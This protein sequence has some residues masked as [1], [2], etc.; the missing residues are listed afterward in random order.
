MQPQKL[1]QS[2]LSALRG[3][4]GQGNVLTSDEHRLCYA[5][6][7]QRLECVPDAIVRPADTAQIA[8][9][10]RLANENA[11]PVIPRGAGTGLS[12]GSVAAAGGVVL[13]VCRLDRI[14]QIDETNMLLTAQPGVVTAKLVSAAEKLGLLYPPDPGSINACTIGGNVAENS[15]GLRA[16][17]Y[18]VTGDYLKALEVVSPLGEVYR[19]GA[20]TVKSVAGY[21]VTSL[22]CGSEGTLG[23]LTEITV[24]LIPIPRFRRSLLAVFDTVRGAT[25]AVVAI[26]TCGVLPATLEMM[27]GMTI[28]HVE[29]ANHIGLPVEA[30]AI[31]LIEVDGYSDAGVAEE[32]EIVRAALA[33]SEA[34]EMKT[35]D[36]PADRERLWEA[37]RSAI[38]A[39]ARAR[40]TTML[41]DVTVPVTA[42]S[43]MTLFI[44]Q[45]AREHS[46]SVATFGHAG[47]GNLHPT[48]LADDRDE[49]E[50]AR[51]KQA[52]AEIFEKAIALGGTVSGEH[53]IGMTKTRFLPMETGPATIEVMRS[54]K[55]AMDPNNILNPGKVFFED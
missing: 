8:A 9:V 31:L 10:L 40:P 50:I 43:E 29:Q 13:D 55:R 22:L 32:A 30:E 42:L 16:V 5:Y 15:G 20:R 18:G 36:N 51:V 47:D 39:L 3:I 19:T 11:F 17:K 4:V 45:M 1:S 7:A 53:G 48:F 12:G 6:D 27:D 34:S 49:D 33:K 2:T 25:D 35:A 44:Q 24:K 54:I 52:T 37:R 21:N 14:V 38:P 26:M 28:R 23:V 46:V 41:E